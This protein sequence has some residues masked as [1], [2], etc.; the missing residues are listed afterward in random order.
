MQGIFHEI[1]NELYHYNDAIGMIGL[2][3]VISVNN[4]A[5]ICREQTRGTLDSPQ[6]VRCCIHGK[7]AE[8]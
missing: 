4:L 1:C 6:H 5:I 8:E 7:Y 2:L 3:T